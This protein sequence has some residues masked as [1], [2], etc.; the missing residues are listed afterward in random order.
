MNRSKYIIIIIMGSTY[1]TLIIISTLFES[2]KYLGKDVLF[3]VYF[4]SHK[5]NGKPTNS[6]Y[7]SFSRTII[8]CFI[9][10][11]RVP[12]NVNSIVFVSIFSEKF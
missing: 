4:S 11:I 9:L 8:E 10:L 3:V 5:E 2:S 7:E 12:E 1:Y 6:F